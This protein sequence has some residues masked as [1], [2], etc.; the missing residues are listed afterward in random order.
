MGAHDSQQQ[1]QNHGNSSSTTPREQ[2]LGI[3][4]SGKR[5]T[6]NLSGYS[7]QSSSSSPNTTTS[8]SSSN[9]FSTS[10]SILSNS[11]S[12]VSSP[13]H[14]SMHFTN[15]I[16]YPSSSSSATTTGGGGGRNRSNSSS[17]THHQYLGATSP[18]TMS[19]SPHNAISPNTL[20]SHIQN[21]QQTAKN[22]QLHAK[23]IQLAKMYKF[24]FEEIYDNHETRALFKQFLIK[25]QNG[26]N[27]YFDKTLDSEYKPLKSN[28][29]RYY[30]AKRIVETFIKEGSPY[31]VNLSE[32]V[33]HALL[34]EFAKAS[35]EN[36]P[37]DLF[38]SV[39]YQVLSSMRMDAYPRFVQSDEFLSFIGSKLLNAKNMHHKLRFLKAINA[40][41]KVSPL[42]LSSSKANLRK[43]LNV[44]QK[45]TEEDQLKEALIMDQIELE[46]NAH[47]NLILH[48]PDADPTLTPRSY[49]TYT[50]APA[51]GQTAPSLNSPNNTNNHA[52][53]HQ[54]SEISE[55]STIKRSMS[56]LMGHFFKSGDKQSSNEKNSNNR[57]STAATPVQP[58]VHTTRNR[59]SRSGSA[60]GLSLGE[61]T[62]S[63]NSIGV[64][65]H[66]SLP[67]AIPPINNFIVTPGS[68]DEH[69]D[70]EDYSN[71][72]ADH[73]D[74]ED[75]D[76]IP[77]SEHERVKRFDTILSKSNM[78][79]QNH[80]HHHHHQDEMVEVI[81]PWQDV[82]SYISGDSSDDDEDEL[83][84]MDIGGNLAA[85]AGTHV[86]S[87][88]LTHNTI[89]PILEGL[90]THIEDLQ[91]STREVEAIKSEYMHYVDNKSVLDLATI[92]KQ[93]DEKDK[94]TKSG[95][96]MVNLQPKKRRL[97]RRSKSISSLDLIAQ[98]SVKAYSARFDSI[99]TDDITY[100][101]R[102]SCRLP[103]NAFSVLQILADESTDESIVN[104]L[105]TSPAE[106]IEF[107]VK[108]TEHAYASLITLEGARWP[109]PLKQRHYVTTGTVISDI[110]NDEKDNP[111]R[112]RY[113][114]IKRSVV[115][116]PKLE[117]TLSK[118]DNPNRVFGLKLEA[119]FIESFN[120][121][122]CTLTMFNEWKFTNANKW[123]FPTK[124]FRKTLRTF[125]TDFHQNLIDRLSSSAGH[126]PISYHE[127]ISHT[128]TAHDVSPRNDHTLLHTLFRNQAL[129][130]YKKKEEIKGKVQ[131][132]FNT[133]SLMRLFEYDLHETCRIIEER[134]HNSSATTP[135]DDNNQ[136]LVNPSIH[137][138]SEESSQKQTKVL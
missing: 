53:T 37:L 76:D 137:I 47:E 32:K 21:M 13:P 8:V 31:E 104:P 95:W 15:P 67:K 58:Y 68:D 30:M 41:R 82:E 72:T 20:Q 18:S 61:L 39:Q 1:Q 36:C 127:F 44:K 62:T 52:H 107:I 17:S 60:L 25:N 84:Q 9:V 35:E 117:I 122:E 124:L 46:D 89:V 49:Y 99:A 59:H 128:N 120:T 26:E 70:E 22:E 110:I 119:Y 97:G 40:V 12:A 64:K 116:N 138:V 90:S 16:T 54:T 129:S 114:I 71:N 101:L 115:N 79:G 48:I 91:L 102:R 81:D 80:N 7:N 93:V 135:S 77:L 11:N 132:V 112:K 38:D 65:L 57:K 113:V 109:W 131:S 136:H 74:N 33:K 50:S 123:S 86:N 55:P 85:I 118:K 75:D 134:Y 19:T 45:K 125:S 29:N 10:S 27:I 126:Q 106:Y 78:F 14:H 111:G 94:K 133:L 34:R 3:P 43:S 103:Y 56:N 100:M 121:N 73:Q 63:S 4:L 51:N 42:E 108:E 88:P 23:Q 2:L 5:A 66:D 96:S 83:D 28:R 87:S 92:L 130:P 24:Q 69:D 98:H 6:T 105:L